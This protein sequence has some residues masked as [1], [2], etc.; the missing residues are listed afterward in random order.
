MTIRSTPRHRSTKD[1]GSNPNISSCGTCASHPV[2]RP[3]SPSICDKR[4][5]SLAWWLGRKQKA[6]TLSPGMK[7]HQ[8]SGGRKLRQD[9]RG[10]KPEKEGQPTERTAVWQASEQRGASRKTLS[11]H[12]S[13]GGNPPPRTLWFCGEGAGS[14]P[15]ELRE[16]LQATCSHSLGAPWDKQ[17]SWQAKLPLHGTVGH[18]LGRTLEWSEII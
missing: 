15:L 13:A 4:K 16:C 11:V 10:P 7:K 8:A 17:Q 12:P 14:R 2:P 18:Q 9:L 5:N 3:V 6:Q 1:K